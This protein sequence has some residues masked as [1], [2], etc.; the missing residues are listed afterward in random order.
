MPFSYIYQEILILFLVIQNKLKFGGHLGFWTLISAK[1]TNLFLADTQ[2]W[3]AYT[4][5]PRYSVHNWGMG[6]KYVIS[7][8]TLYQGSTPKKLTLLLFCCHCFSAISFASAE[9]FGQNRKKKN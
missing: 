3:I 2:F 4:V 9:C 8:C 5:E 1:T 7:K 6:K